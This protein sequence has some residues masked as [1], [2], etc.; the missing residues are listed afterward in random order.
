LSKKR[1]QRAAAVATPEEKKIGHPAVPCPL[2]YIAA[3]YALGLPW[4]VRHVFQ[5]WSPPASN[6][7][8]WL[9]D[10]HQSSRCVRVA[11]AITRSIHRSMAERPPVERAMASYAAW[12]SRC[13]SPW[14]HVAQPASPCWSQKPPKHGRPSQ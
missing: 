9:I 3:R 2:V 1:L 8:Q 12:R 7:W 10:L 13:T 4:S 5:T 6:P 14:A 11:R